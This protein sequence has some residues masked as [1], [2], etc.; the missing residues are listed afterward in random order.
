MLFGGGEQRQQR[1]ARDAPARGCPQQGGGGRR[2]RGRRRQQQ[3]RRRRRG[4][5]PGGAADPEQPRGCRQ[6][7]GPR[8]RRRRG[9]GGGGCPEKGMR[10]LGW[11]SRQH[12][13]WQEGGPAG[14]GGSLPA[15]PRP[16]PPSETRGSP[17]G[18]APPAAGRGEDEGRGMRL[19][20]PLPRVG[21]NG[22]RAGE[23]PRT[24]TAP[25]VG[26]DRGLA[27]GLEMSLERGTGGNFWRSS[28]SAPLLGRRQPQQLAQETPQPL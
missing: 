24:E 19:G 12:P 17:A 1:L 28:S 20:R 6:H 23:P 15:P 14:P 13:T 3:R 8:W 22:K 9:L 18:K 25:G 4:G 26:G 5:S 7:P 16:P 10:A 11:G 27:A 21:A 2:G